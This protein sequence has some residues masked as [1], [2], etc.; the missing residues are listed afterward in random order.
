MEYWHSKG[1]GLVEAGQRRTTIG[2][3]FARPGSR[4]AAGT[5]GLRLSFLAAVTQRPPAVRS[6]A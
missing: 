1:P 6:R 5:P 4:P 2:P 3:L